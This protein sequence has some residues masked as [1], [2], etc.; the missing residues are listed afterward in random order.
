MKANEVAEGEYENIREIA[1]REVLEKAIE[2][3]KK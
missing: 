2:V 1:M 3:K